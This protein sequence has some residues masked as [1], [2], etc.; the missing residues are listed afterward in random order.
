MGL[1]QKTVSGFIWTS[2]GMLGNGLVSFLVTMI[3]ARILLPYDF[4]LVQLLA[5]FLAISNVVVDSG[6]SQ[7]I[8]R[9]DD[10][11]ETDLSSVFYF[12]ICLSFIVYIILFFAAPQISSYFAAPELTILSRVVFLVIIFNS[13]SIIQNATLNR[14]LE[15]ALVNRASVTGSFLAG[16]IS[17]I[18]AFT[19][20]GIWALVAN[21][22]LLPFFRSILLWYHSSWRPIK[23]FSIKSVKRYFGFGGFLMVQGIVDAIST[24]L[25]SLI[26]GR[27]YT[28]DDLGYY[29]QGKKL[30]GYIVTPFNSIIQKVTYPILSKIKNEGARLKEGYRKI[31]GVVMFAFIPVMLFTIGTSDNMIITLFGEKWAEAGIYLKIAAVGALLFPIQYV[32]T[33]IIMIKG[34]TNIMLIFSVIKHGIRIVLLLAFINSGV[35]AL[36]IVYTSSTLIGSILY[37]YLGMKYLHYSIFELFND[38]YKSVF[39]SLIALAPILLLDHYMVHLNTIFVFVLQGITMVILYLMTSLLFKNE[40]LSEAVSMVK[41]ILLKIKR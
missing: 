16:G 26:I 4:A 28:K 18:M 25:I 22:V 19:G 29:S 35:L 27:V 36:A 15:F 8:I 41:P 11:S 2:A 17:I 3:L 13:F 21:M 9:D 24:N 39:S 38:L 6:F 10:P 33:N 14:S 32:C 20:F 37:I 40:Y 5:V 31:V 7:A 34:K 12:N 23:A 30:D 1:K